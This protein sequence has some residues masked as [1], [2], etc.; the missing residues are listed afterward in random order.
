[1]KR[2][3]VLSAGLILLLPAAVIAKKMD[4]SDLKTANDKLNYAVG[5]DVGRSVKR[6]KMSV[7]KDIFFQGMLDGETDDGSSDSGLLTASERIE[8]KQ[9]HVQF[10]REIERE[11][12]LA[13]ADENLK[14][15]KAFLKKNKRQKGVTTTESGL[16]YRMVKNS[17]GSKPTVED[18]VT[19]HYKGTLVDGTEFDSSYRRNKPATF[20]VSRVVKGWTEALQL[21]SVRSKWIV[22]IP[23]ELG[24]GE[25]GAGAKIPP[26][27]VLIFEIEL[28]EI[29]STRGEDGSGENNTDS[30]END[31]DENESSLNVADILSI[32]VYR[33]IGYQNNGTSWSIEI[34]VG[35][36][37]STIKYPS[38]FCGGVLS[39]KRVT[40]T[41]VEF[42][43][44]ITYGD[45]CVDNGIT[46]VSTT[47]AADTFHY[48]WQYDNGV[49]GAVG[50]VRRDK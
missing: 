34:T 46:V 35:E 13:A 10:R 38:L 42:Y 15:A 40:D 49:A 11:E 19:V 32:G 14:K 31:N 21:M 9:A 1:M 24:Y 27:S 48:Y 7:D 39:V 45:N 44:D 43:E 16:Q 22:Y 29:D 28:L 4:R 30:A 8:V 6:N 47:D 36:E 50:T 41:R 33:G 25:R 18:T 17:K 37:T 23:P 2:A 20:A 3:W 26:N 12:Q 5:Y